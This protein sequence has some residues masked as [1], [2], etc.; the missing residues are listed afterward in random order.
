MKRTGCG[1]LEHS[2]PQAYKQMKVTRTKLNIMEKSSAVTVSVTCAMT[3][4]CCCAE[5]KTMMQAGL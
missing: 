2:L 5:D 1:W 3:A 4:G